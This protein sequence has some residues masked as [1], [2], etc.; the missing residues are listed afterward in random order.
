MNDFLDIAHGPIA[1]DP[2]TGTAPPEFKPP[3]R[4]H[5][6]RLIDFPAR[7]FALPPDDGMSFNR[8]LFSLAAW[9]VLAALLWKVG[10]FDWLKKKLTA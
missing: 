5:V 9:L 1:F 10:V 8:S 7:V 3:L 2:G 4:Y 6:G